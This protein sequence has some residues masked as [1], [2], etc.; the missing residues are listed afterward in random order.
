MIHQ[1]QVWV[2]GGWCCHMAQTKDRR[3]DRFKDVANKVAF[4]QDHFNVHWMFSGTE[5]IKANVRS[6]IL[7]IKEFIDL[8]VRYLM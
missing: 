1:T 2:G 7:T 4:D 6:F 5:C 8:N 3:A